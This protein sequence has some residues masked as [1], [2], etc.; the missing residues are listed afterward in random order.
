MISMMNSAPPT[1]HSEGHSNTRPLLL[2]G[3]HFIWWKSRIEIFIQG[4]EYE[5]WDRITDGPTILMKLVDG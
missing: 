2:D 1:G 3:S 5:I 4:K